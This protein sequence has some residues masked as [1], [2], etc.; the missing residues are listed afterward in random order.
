[1]IDRKS[2]GAGESDD[3]YIESFSI[4]EPEVIVEKFKPQKLVTCER[5]GSNEKPEFATTRESCPRCPEFNSKTCICGHQALYHGIWIGALTGHKFWPCR[6]CLN[7]AEESLIG[8]V[9]TD[10][11]EKK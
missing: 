8:G 2:Q 10:F 11:K 5:C 9:C 7:R 1:M 6:G 4:P 3:D